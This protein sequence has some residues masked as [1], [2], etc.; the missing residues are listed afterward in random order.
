M[1]RK[2]ISTNPIFSSAAF[3]MGFGRSVP[4]LHLSVEITLLPSWKKADY[5]PRQSHYSVSYEFDA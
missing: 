1:P 4:P 5:Q 2:A 3:R